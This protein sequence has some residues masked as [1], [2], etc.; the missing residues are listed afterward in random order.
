LP[1]MAEMAGIFH[2]DKNTSTIWRYSPYNGEYHY[3]NTSKVLLCFKNGP[4]CFK[5]ASKFQNCSHWYTLFFSHYEALIMKH[6]ETF[7][8]LSISF[9]FSLWNISFYP[10]HFEIFPFHPFLV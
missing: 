8:I 10:F 9:W 7:S 3:K 1:G 4:E 5:Y 2:N 6:N